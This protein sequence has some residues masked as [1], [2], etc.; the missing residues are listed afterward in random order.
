MT[1]AS[2]AV[3]L[4]YASEDADSARRLRDAL[5]A[6]GIEVWFDQSEL[7]GGDVWDQKIRQ[8]VRD[9]ALFV[10]IISASTAA[11]HE[12]YFRLEWDLADER[13]HML[14]R[15]R[16]FV[17]PVC[18]DDTP[19]SATDVPE[20][21][22]RVQW[23][24]LAAGATPAAFVERIAALLAPVE[25]AG[26]ATR[27]PANVASRPPAR[28][29]RGYWLLAGGVLVLAS[30]YLAASRLVPQWRSDTGS[31][32]PAAVVPVAPTGAT[33]SIAVL[34]FAD[35]SAAQDQGYFAD[36][37]AEEILDLLAKI[38]QLKVIA[39]T[40][41]FQFKGKAL[42]IRTI[43]AELGASYVVE[44]SVRRSG[45]RVRIVAQL[46]DARDGTHVWSQTYERTADDVFA[47]QDDVATGIA[48]ALQISTGAYD[49][50]AHRPTANRAAYDEYLRGSLEFDQTTAASTE[51]AAAAFER[52]LAL[53]PMFASAAEAL[54]VTRALQ[55]DFGFAPA[56]EAVE[57]ERA[58][59]ELALRL[60]PI[61]ARAHAILGDAAMSTLDWRT[62]QREIARARELGPRD[63]WVVGLAAKLAIVLGKW[64]EATTLISAVLD[65]DPLSAAGHQMAEYA[66]AG[67]GRLE[68]AEGECRQILRLSPSFETIRYELALILLARGR[69]A[70]ALR[71]AS[72]EP[73]PGTRLMGIAITQAALGHL[74]ESDAALRLAEKSLKDAPSGLAQIYAMR[75][76]R[77]RAFALLDRAASLARA[78]PDSFLPFIQ[79]Y[80]AWAPLRADP[81]Y[82]ALLQR[83]NLAE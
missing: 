13:T 42:D 7:R 48:R 78:T 61:S 6:A 51:R 63:I 19:H 80:L 27:P 50:G 52:A 21:F 43:G 54:A 12:G 2:R 5:A 62:A 38:P 20:S 56:R 34:P 26:A 44:G 39:R 24:R 60:D 31:G 66:Y 79:C 55:G 3:F 57:K 1:N 10:P 77:D 67:A 18:I 28:S 70:D 74:T 14:A 75:G 40:S 73:D 17:V 46:I 4:S 33:R 64:G 72:E 9:C 71:A 8:Q 47:M 15:D 29:R 25:R 83:L 45:N 65:I 76:D 23:T 69:A 22:R 30:A 16:S 82:H 32:A 81:R 68:E 49:I 53:D 41:S 11:R 37:M 59:A 36:G 58:A 35:M